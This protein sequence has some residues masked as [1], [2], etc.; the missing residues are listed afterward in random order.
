MIKNT[1]DYPFKG[2][3]CKHE[4]HLSYSW[5]GVRAKCNDCGAMSGLSGDCDAPEVIYH[6]AARPQTPQYCELWLDDT[7]KH[8]LI[9]ANCVDGDAIWAMEPDT[10]AMGM[11]PLSGSNKIGEENFA[12]VLERLEQQSLSGCSSSMWWC[13]WAYEGTHHARSVWYYIA[14]LRADPKAHSCAWGRIYA[15]AYSAIMCQGVLKPCLKF[16]NDIPEFQAKK[17]NSIDWLQAVHQAKAAQHQPVN[18]AILD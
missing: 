6:V 18:I 7:G 16:L 13:A 2:W 1:M 15:D 17:L 12:A 14:A 4:D 11:M 9:L 8:W 3:R 5:N 10:G